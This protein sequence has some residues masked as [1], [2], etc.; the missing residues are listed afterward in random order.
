LKWKTRKRGSARQ[1]GQKFPVREKKK[2]PARI[3]KKPKIRQ[4]AISL[5]KSHIINKFGG[6]RF[7]FDEIIKRDIGRDGARFLLKHG[8]ERSGEGAKLLKMRISDCHEN[9]LELT[10]KHPEKYLGWYGFALSRDGIWR[11]HS[12]VT[13]ENNKIIETTVLRIKYFGVPERR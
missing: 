12:W 1:I 8:V 7:Q 13:D 11:V 2:L 6:E 5:L 10:K 4:D 9:V 3:T